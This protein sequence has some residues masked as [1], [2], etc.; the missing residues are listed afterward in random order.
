MSFSELATLLEKK[1]LEGKNDIEALDIIQRELKEN[2]N[3]SKYYR[4]IYN[5]INL[6]M[7]NVVGYINL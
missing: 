7:R 5:F 3:K 6:D 4:K 1:N 2:Y